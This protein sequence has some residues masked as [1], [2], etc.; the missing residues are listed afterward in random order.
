MNRASSEA[1][2]AVAALHCL[3]DGLADLGGDLGTGRSH[4]LAWVG[5]EA[6][7]GLLGLLLLN[8]GRVDCDEVRVRLVRLRGHRLVLFGLDYGLKCL[9]LLAHIRIVLIFGFN[10][11][12]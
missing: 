12:L 5:F 4:G 3:D 6:F 10:F 11:K 2:L 8:G 1:T 7:Y 9:I